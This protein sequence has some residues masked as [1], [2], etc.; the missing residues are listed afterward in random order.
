MSEQ[1]SA[2]VVVVGA[3]ICGGTVAKE[4]AE[5]GLSV[6]VLDAGSRWERGEVVENWRNMPPVNKSESDYATP[7]PDKPWAVH[8]QLNPYNNYPEVSGPDASAFKQGMIKGVGGTTWHWAASCWRFLPADMQLHS[9]Y[10][11]GRDWVVNYDELE[12]Y[13]YRAEVLIGVNGPNDTSLKYV[14][15]R[16]KPFPMEPMPYGPA[17]RRFTE[18]V[19]QAG[20]ENTPVP[21]GRNSRPY[22]GRP[23]CCGNNNC[24]PICPIGAMYNGIHS[25]IKAE[26]AGAKIVPNA[27]VYRIDTDEHNNVT[28]LYYYDP[29]KNSHKVTARTFV[30]AGNGI[31]TPKLLLMAANDKNP[32]GIANSSDMVGRNMMDH[33]GIL[34]S[35]QSAEPVW[36]GGGSV[37][38][39]SITNFRDGDFRREHSAIQI[40]MNNTSQNHK[41]GVKALQMGLVGKK[42]DAEIRRRAACGM[43]IYVNHDILANPDNR[44]T[45][46]TQYKD[47]L[48]IPYPHVTYDVGDYV[49]KAA[50]SSRQHLMQIAN[51]FGATEIEMTPYFN[52]N[53]HIMGG[54]IGGHDPKDS[55]VDAWMRT[56][57]HQ[58]L[59]IASGGV[60]AA[61]GTVNS[62]LSMVA[63]SLR[64]CDSIKRDLQHG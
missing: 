60:M 51:L 20:Y 1:Y 47:S 56:H 54:T 42:L 49:R 34:M 43:D 5:A 9:T 11:V 40:G 10:G 29:D 50:V 4:L 53:N 32:N 22:D 48:G 31:E 27:V 14:A 18:V 61:A 16:K 15:P 63:L 41:A 25:V 7:Y 23:Q 57:D 64:A 2:D 45:L 37:Q 17:D 28:A 36:T 30:L 62:T 19:A 8:P 55:V 58:N 13:Y 24:M 52:P 3:G 44:L 26:K 59:Y 39:S 38:M 35:F 6:L 12:D 46:S 21:Q 33:P